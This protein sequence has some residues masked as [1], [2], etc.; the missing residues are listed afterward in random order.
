MASCDSTQYSNDDFDV[1][2]QHLGAI[3]V[4]IFAG[5]LSIVI[6]SYF[7]YR[8]KL[9]LKWLGQI[10]QD[11]KYRFRHSIKLA[12]CS[13]IAS[14]GATVFKTIGKINILLFD[15]DYILCAFNCSPTVCTF[16]VATQRVHHCFTQLRNCFYY[17][18]FMQAI[19][20]NF[21]ASTLRA[22]QRWLTILRSITITMTT[23]VILVTIIWDD[24]NLKQVENSQYLICFPHL[25]SITGVVFSAHGTFQAILTIILVTVFLAK[26]RR[27]MKWHEMRDTKLFQNHMNDFMKQYDAFFEQAKTRPND[28]Q[29]QIE[30]QRHTD[31]FTHDHDQERIDDSAAAASKKAEELWQLAYP[32]D[33][34][35]RLVLIMLRHTS[36]LCTFFL[37]EMI[38]GSL[39]AAFRNSVD[40]T[41]L[42]QITINTIIYMLYP[43]G[44]T[45][46]SCCCALCA[47]NMF[48]CWYNGYASKRTQTLGNISHQSSQLRSMSNVSNGSNNG[49]IHGSKSDQGMRYPQQLNNI[50]DQHIQIH[51]ET[52]TLSM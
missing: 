34:L 30:Q 47:R 9:Q 29:L 40:S 25:N 15:P 10:A 24:G 21:S 35:S 12:V 22:N 43:V 8:F 19:D 41:N 48:I 37:V 38:H 11:R 44:D 52:L 27:L 17:L 39:V 1:T 13:M 14:I 31:I 49:S 51:E 5:F 26:A 50:P 23:S 32:S 6:A 42:K 36:L 7:V 28:A 20:D 18:I 45:M 46:F 16:C 3:Q 4:D 2:N 33:T